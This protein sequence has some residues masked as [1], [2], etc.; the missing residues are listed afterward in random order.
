MFGLSDLPCQSRETIKELI[1]F[2]WNVMELK[3]K[4]HQLLDHISNSPCFNVS[5]GFIEDALETDT[6]SINVY[7][8]GPTRNNMMHHMQILKPELLCPPH[9]IASDNHLALNYLL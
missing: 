3:V 8:W 1:L 4:T 9:Y 7:Q 5:K 2:C 6:V